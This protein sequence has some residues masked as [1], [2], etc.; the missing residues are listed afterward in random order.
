MPQETGAPAYGSMYPR[1][2]SKNPSY[3]G[4]YASIAPVGMA[5]EEEEDAFHLRR[6]RM[7]VI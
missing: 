4:M 6:R 2:I 3:T 7:H 5:K 1:W